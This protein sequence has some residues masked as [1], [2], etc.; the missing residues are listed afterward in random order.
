MTDKKILDMLK[1]IILEI[2]YDIYK[3]YFVNQE[4]PEFIEEEIKNLISIVK[5]YID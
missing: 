5:E 2:D 1:S 3:G 4:D